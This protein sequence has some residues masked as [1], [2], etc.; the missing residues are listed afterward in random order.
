M[1]PSDGVTSL[2][3]LILVPKLR[4]HA[5]GTCEFE[6]PRTT[7]EGHFLQSG[8]ENGATKRTG[9]S[10]R[11]RQSVIARTNLVSAVITPMVP[12]AYSL[13]R[14]SNEIPVLPTDQPTYQLT[15][16]YAYRNSVR[17]K[18]P[19]F[20]NTCLPAPAFF[21]DVTLGFLSACSSLRVAKPAFSD[22]V[23][24]RMTKGGEGCW[25]TETD[26]EN[27]PIRTC[28]MQSDSWCGS[29]E[30]AADEEVRDDCHGTNWKIGVDTLSERKRVKNLNIYSLGLKEQ[31]LSHEVASY[32]LDN[33]GPV[34]MAMEF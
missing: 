7:D 21:L 26:Y 32:R 9:C 1:A 12:V 20:T 22:L 28:F 14:A 8:S 31:K 25:G 15:D 30:T 29:S 23:V 17:F 4:R 34:A 11:Q 27:S 13:S 19:A 10:A 18:I 6:Y 2:S 3:I 24:S 33:V 16:R 5:T